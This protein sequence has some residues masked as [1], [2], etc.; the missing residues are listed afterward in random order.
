MH[1]LQCEATLTFFQ[2]DHGDGGMPKTNTLSDLAT[3]S[4]PSV[5][6]P[7]QG[8][9]RLWSYTS[10]SSMEDIER[11]HF[12]CRW[13]LDEAF[14]NATQRISLQLRVISVTLHS[15]PHYTVH[16]YAQ[17]HT[18]IYIYIYIYMH[19]VSN[20]RTFNAKGPKGLG[21]YDHEDRKVYKSTVG[22]KQ[23]QAPRRNH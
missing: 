11:S 15:S 20:P 3:T 4:A 14:E 12:P 5:C 17:V 9:W 10:R 8:L 22:P 13:A 23:G 19:T 6:S 18:S 1:S 16:G 2:M 21:L 7:C